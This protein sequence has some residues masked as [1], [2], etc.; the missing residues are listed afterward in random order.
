MLAN[1]K[2]LNAYST[3]IDAQ[4]ESASPHRLIVLLFDGA[5]KAINLAKF[6]MQQGNTAEK[7]KAISKAIAIIEEGLRLSLDKSKGGELTE[8]LDALY[9]YVAHQ[10]L[11]ANL[12]ND[13]ALLDQALTLLNDLKT[14]WSSIDP[15]LNVS[16]QTKLDDAARDGLSYG[17]A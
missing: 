7:G 12:R 5:I 17:R 16:E 15:L 14:A 8:N 13:E 1:K 10:L 2:A 4:V 6:Q 3:S 9:E 11:T